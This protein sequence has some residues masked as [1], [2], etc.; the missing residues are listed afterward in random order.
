M[1]KGLP[2]STPTVGIPDTGWL[3]L[4]KVEKVAKEKFEQKNMN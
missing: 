2:D 1:L 4:F 3:Q